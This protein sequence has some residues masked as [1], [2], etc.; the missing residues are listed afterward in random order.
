MIDEQHP[1]FQ[2]VPCLSGYGYE[3]AHSLSKA[4]ERHLSTT[5]KSFTVD[6]LRQEFREVCCVT[7]SR[8]AYN[9]ALGTLQRQGKVMKVGRGVYQHKKWG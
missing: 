2:T 3:F 9:S 7:S 8:Q 5:P 4:I 1:I 6:A